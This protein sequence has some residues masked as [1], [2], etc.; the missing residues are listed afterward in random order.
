MVCNNWWV[1]A[2]SS[3]T[4]FLQRKWCSCRKSG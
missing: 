3:Y 2:K 1:P 4:A